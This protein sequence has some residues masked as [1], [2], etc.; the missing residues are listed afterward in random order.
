MSNSP[1]NVTTGQ[2]RLSYVH[3]FTPYANQPGQAAKYSTTVLLPK[4]DIATKQ[5]ID[6]AINAAIMMGVTS[7]WGGVR[8]PQVKNPIWDGDGLRQSGEP[9]APEARGHWVFTASSNHQP[10][11]VDTGNNPILDQTAIYSG[12][13]ARVALNFFPFFSNGNKG[14]GC[15]LGPVQKLS[16][17]EPLGGQISAEAA[18]AD[19]VGVT[20]VPPA[21]Q[22]YGQP[23]PQQQYGQP[24]PQYAPPVPNYGQPVPNNAPPVP[25]YSQPVQPSY[26][27][28]AQPQQQ[29]APPVQQ[30]AQPNYSQP[31]QQYTQ[32]PVQPQYGQPVQPQQQYAQAVDPIT[33]LPLPIA[34][35]VMGL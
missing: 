19:S 4:S 32:P 33:G 28:P 25:N 27:Q 1:T 16:D 2:V 6:A 23:A 29:Y 35:G 10:V 3:L 5:R 34:G 9:F 18:F 11:V 12:I 22:N 24:V 26:G 31:V 20:Y 14:I 7:K 13:Y 8:P 15:G 21:P 30:L 17:G